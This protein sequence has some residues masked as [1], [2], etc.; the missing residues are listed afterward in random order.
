MDMI[1]YTFNAFFFFISTPSKLPCVQM[2][3]RTPNTCTFEQII[4]QES[5]LCVSR[6]YP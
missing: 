1:D 5:N 3:K 6:T 4:K 2:F